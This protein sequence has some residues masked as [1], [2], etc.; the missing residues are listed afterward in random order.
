MTQTDSTRH[1]TPDTGSW[2]PLKDA[3]QVLGISEY[4]AY[5]FVRDEKLR[6]REWDGGRIEVWISEADDPNGV[7]SLPADSHDDRI[8]LATV[9]RLSTVFQQQ[10]GELLRP[11]SESHERRVELARENGALV[12]RLA[13][14]ER[15]A[16]AASETIAADKES[17]A[18][19][20]KRV[21]DV[22]EA[23]TQ[24]TSML[25]SKALERPVEQPPKRPWTW[26]VVVGILAATTI[27]LAIV[28]L[29][30]VV[31]PA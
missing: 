12:E 4:Q 23:N 20:R 3:L 19:L 8:S 26:M 16:T 15:E 28:L 29:L 2:L 18:Y 5:R 31:R 27:G 21:R 10:V 7:Q 25:N 17:T 6:A 14:A 9:E 22:E 1:D 24:L 13:A 11:L 30:G